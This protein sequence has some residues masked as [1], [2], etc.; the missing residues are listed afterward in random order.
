M[1]FDAA[2]P[3]CVFFIAFFVL[4]CASLAVFHLCLTSFPEI[5]NFFFIYRFLATGR[6]YTDLHYSFR[7]GIATISL[8][9][10]EVC[11]VIWQTLHDECIPTKT[12][13]MWQEIAN[14]F[15]QKTNFPNCIGA[16]DG[17][18][19]RIVNPAGGGSMF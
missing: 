3:E 8:I 9:V 12:S 15:L 16:I 10:D 7:I 1:Y 2:L 18:H 17:K 13:D 19:I 14:G 4:K 11:K 5:I 6:K